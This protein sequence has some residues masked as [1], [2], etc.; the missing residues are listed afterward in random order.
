MKIRILN[1]HITK[2]LISNFLLILC[3]YFI[4]SCSRNNKP[5]IKFDYGLVNYDSLSLSLPDTIPDINLAKS[6]S[7]NQNYLSIIFNAKNLVIYRFGFK[8]K[9]WSSIC[10]NCSDKYLIEHP[11]S[12]DF[13]NDSTII[14][15]NQYKHEL[16]LIDLNNKSVL[17]KYLLSPDYSMPQF[18]KLKI[19]SNQSCIYLPVWYLNRIDNSYGNNAR[20]ALKIDR[21]TDEIS[22][23]GNFPSNIEINKNSSLNNIT[24]D[25]IFQADCFV[26]NFKK[27]KQLYKFDYKL[28]KY[29]QI[30]CP[31]LNINDKKLGSASE[32]E[33]KN[34]VAEELSG[35]YKRLL[36]DEINRLYY[37]I[38][39][40]YPAYK[41]DLTNNRDEILKL[42]KSH[43]VMISVLDS[44]L[45]ILCQKKIE[46]VTEHHCFTRNGI[47]YLK[48][49]SN[50]ENCVKYFGFKLRKT[51]NRKNTANDDL[52]SQK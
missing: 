43:E 12:F 25:I 10:L 52:S 46:G 13:L 41:G 47:L 42:F 14:I 1:K 39:V 4:I 33:I 28:N 30:N 23:F 34:A 44:N 11:G 9:K 5:N 31:D 20:L 19:F 26:L 15:V 37:R 48:K 21:K 8:K 17:K 7:H 2:L 49:E 36:Y 38:S 35:Q 40:S 50:E 16:L 32:D 3:F 45:K 6:W 24:P 22:Y 51:D 29:F 27:D 18:S